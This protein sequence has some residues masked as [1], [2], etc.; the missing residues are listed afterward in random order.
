MVRRVSGARIVWRMQM[1]EAAARRQQ[2]EA[3]GSPPCDH[4]ELDKLYYLGAQDI[5]KVCTE[6]GQEF[7]PEELKRMGR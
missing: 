2:W 4:L 1:S 7:S 6:C 5:D 3:K